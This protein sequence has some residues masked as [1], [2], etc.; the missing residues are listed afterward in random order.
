[1]GEAGIRSQELLVLSDEFGSKAKV[2]LKLKCRSGRS[3]IL[4]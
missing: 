4:R 3:V 2:I 1:M